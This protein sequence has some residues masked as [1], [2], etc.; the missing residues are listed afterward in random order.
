[1]IIT[2]RLITGNV[3]DVRGQRYRIHFL[4]ISQVYEFTWV[5]DDKGEVGYLH[6]KTRTEQEVA[7]AIMNG[8]I[9]VV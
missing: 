6:G 3:Y 4:N 1:M 2:P 9:K 7:D 8:I 5:A